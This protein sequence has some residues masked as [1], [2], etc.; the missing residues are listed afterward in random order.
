MNPCFS[1]PALQRQVFSN[2]KKALGLDRCRFFASGA[3]PLNPDAGLAVCALG[4]AMGFVIH[5][6]HCRPISPPS[7]FVFA[8]CVCLGQIDGCLLVVQAMQYPPCSSSA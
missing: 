4:F 6:F 2:I 3:A 7:I 1:R 8:R 5:R